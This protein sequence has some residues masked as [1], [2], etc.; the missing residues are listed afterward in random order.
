MPVTL[1]HGLLRYADRKHER[2]APAQAMWNA[3]Y[4]RDVAG[5]LALNVAMRDNLLLLPRW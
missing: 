3:V 5:G 1:W 4:E 2:L